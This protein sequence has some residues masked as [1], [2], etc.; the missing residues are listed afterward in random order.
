[1]IADHPAAGAVVKFV[2]G[3]GQA[4]VEAP[5]GIVHQ[6]AKFHGLDYDLAD[7]LIFI[8]L[9]PEVIPQEVFSF[10]SSVNQE[11][12]GQLTQ[13]AFGFHQQ[14]VDRVRLRCIFL[15]QQG[16]AQK[17][18]QGRQQACVAISS[19]QHRSNLFIPKEFAKAIPTGQGGKQGMARGIFCSTLPVY[20]AGLFIPAALSNLRTGLNGVVR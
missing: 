5:D 15:G 6:Y 12:L 13:E 1:M 18:N 11:V 8:T 20:K 2:G 3:A 14:T 9:E 16:T 7:N 19:S 17:Q 10:V 4:L